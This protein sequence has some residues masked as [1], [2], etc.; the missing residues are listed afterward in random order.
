MI[1]I[2]I[3]SNIMEKKELLSSVGSSMFI[4]YDEEKI[5][6][7]RRLLEE[8][9]EEMKSDFNKVFINNIEEDNGDNDNKKSDKNQKLVY[10]LNDLTDDEIKNV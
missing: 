1:G 3:L 4:E 8:E 7:R 9:I 5:K 2:M 10:W 6:F